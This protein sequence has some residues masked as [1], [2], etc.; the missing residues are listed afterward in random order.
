MVLKVLSMI[1]Q[2]MN[3][4]MASRA[5][6]AQSTE[7]ALMAKKM[8]MTLAMV[9]AGRSWEL[10]AAKRRRKKAKMKPKTRRKKLVVA[11]AGARYSR[12]SALPVRAWRKR[13][14]WVTSP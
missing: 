14:I 8:A 4:L 5:T 6:R 3:S 7:M 11:G 9:A 1:L 2:R 13:S 12:R 10:R